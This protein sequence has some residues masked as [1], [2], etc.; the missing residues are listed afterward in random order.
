MF[1]TTGKP[2]S[3]FSARTQTHSLILALT[4]LAMPALAD[5]APATAL[6]SPSMLATN[7]A[8]PEIISFFSRQERI[9]DLSVTSRSAT[10]SK[11]TYHLEKATEFSEPFAEKDNELLSEMC[12]PKGFYHD[13][14]HAY[15]RGFVFET[16]VKTPGKTYTLV[17][18]QKS[19]GLDALKK[20]AAELFAQSFDA[21]MANLAGKNSL[22]QQM[23][24]PTWD[25]IEKGTVGQIIYSKRGLDMSGFTRSTL[26]AAFCS[27]QEFF[28][29]LAI[30]Y[31]LEFVYTHEGK[32]L[33]FPLKFSDC[34]Q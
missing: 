33:R 10:D 28:T 6:T 27:H 30:G 26:A 4:C 3:N 12:S 32:E 7:L 21:R 11:L 34:A 5:E 1:M 29:M 2:M 23:G 20:T 22:M 31:Q 25:K 18:D 19:C 13:M 14:Q 8:S 16:R 24:Q 17:A 15:L 9:F